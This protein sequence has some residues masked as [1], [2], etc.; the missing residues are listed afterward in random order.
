MKALW[1]WH[2]AEEMEHKAVAFDVYR[3]A[4]GP[5]KLR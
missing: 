2:A 3:A 1:D 4:G 5:E